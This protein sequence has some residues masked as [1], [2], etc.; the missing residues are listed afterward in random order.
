MANSTVMF[1]FRPVTSSGGDGAIQMTKYNILAAYTAAIGIG[2]PV[3][4]NAST[5]NVERWTDGDVLIGIAAQYRAAGAVSADADFMVYDDPNQIF[6]VRTLLADNTIVNLGDLVI[7]NAWPMTL[8]TVNATSGQSTTYL[9]SSGAAGV[10]L[11]GG[12][13]WRGYQLGTGID[14]DNTAANNV[15]HVKLATIAHYHT[16]QS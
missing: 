4:L 15:V 5:G 11:T 8:G 6:E 13:V 3:T 10:N 2:D 14:N 1:G 7:G 9:D 16:R 12:I